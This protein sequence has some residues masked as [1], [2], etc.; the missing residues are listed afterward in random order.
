MVPIIPIIATAAQA[1]GSIWSTVKANQNRRKAEKMADDSF[2][3]T[4]EWR[5]REQR[6]DFTQRADS[7][8]VLRKVRENLDDNL[9][10]LNTSAVRSGATS[11]AKVAAAQKANEAYAG[12]VSEVAAA[13][14]RHKDNVEDIYQQARLGKDALKTQ[15]LMDTSG[16]QNLISNLGQ[17][18]AN[19]GSIYTYGSGKSPVSSTTGVNTTITPQSGG[20]VTK[21]NITPLGKYLFGQ[22]GRK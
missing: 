8:A 1:I 20:K 9:E 3:E 14:Q 5:D 15:N 17:V 2:K 12:A 13:G 4:K 10:A 11:E 22:Y 16:V 19:I 6:S 18:A 21:S 7:Q